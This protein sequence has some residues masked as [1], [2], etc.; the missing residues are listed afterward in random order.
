MNWCNKTTESKWG[1]SDYKNEKI[2]YDVEHK[3]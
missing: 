3:G 2:T 1:M